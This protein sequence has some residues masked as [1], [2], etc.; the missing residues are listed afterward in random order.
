[1]IIFSEPPIN[2]D[3][4]LDSEQFINKTSFKIKI[5]NI[6]SNSLILNKNKKKEKNNNNSPLIKF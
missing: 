4:T 1:M 2:E 3:Y 6:H 5:K